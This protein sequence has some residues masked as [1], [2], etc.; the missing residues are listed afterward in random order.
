MEIGQAVAS[1][2]VRFLDLL[3][4][5][6]REWFVRDGGQ[7][8]LGWVFRDVFGC[9]VTDEE[10]PTLL[11]VLEDYSAGGFGGLTDGHPKP[12]GNAG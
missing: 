10:T 3:E 9:E 12:S 8:D 7:P 2:M 5:D 4:P 6:R 11:G 1:L